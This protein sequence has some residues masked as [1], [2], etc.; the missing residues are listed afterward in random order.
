MSAI[1]NMEK[2]YNCLVNFRNNCNSDEHKKLIDIFLSMLY[3]ENRDR[4]EISVGKKISKLKF[5]QFLSAI[6]TNFVVKLSC[7]S[8]E[9]QIIIQDITQYYKTIVTFNLALIKDLYVESEKGDNNNFF[10]Y[11]IYFNYNNEVDYNIHIA[12]KQWI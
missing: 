5:Y 3:Q 9:P 12:M 8:N 11:N 10:R 6:T 2:S 7:W 4:L 1:V